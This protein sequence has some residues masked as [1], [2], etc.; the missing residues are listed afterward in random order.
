MVVVVVMRPTTTSLEL[1]VRRH[2]AA[3]AGRGEDGTR[4]KPLV[5]QLLSLRVDC[6]HVAVSHGGGAELL[7]GLGDHERHC[8]EAL[9]ERSLV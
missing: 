5:V 3:V 9:F 7:L 4:S 8:L 2:S 6:R 1:M